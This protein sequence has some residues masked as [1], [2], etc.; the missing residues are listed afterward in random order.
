MRRSSVPPQSFE[1]G[2]PRAFQAAPRALD[3]RGW[4]S[5]GLAA[6]AVSAL[7]L[8]VAAS[9]TAT[10]SAEPAQRP[11]D[12][13][14]AQSRPGLPAEGSDAV[15]AGGSTVPGTAVPG[16]GTVTRAGSQPRPAV[17][18]QGALAAFAPQQAP[19]DPTE[20]QVRVAVVKERAAQRAEDLSR[21]AEDASRLTR[22]ASREAR[23]KNLA[24]TDREVRE[25]AVKIAT[26]R[27]QRAIAARVAAEFA[28]KQAEAAA[29]SAAAER[30][31]AAAAAAAAQQADT[32]STSRTPTG[33]VNLPTSSN[34]VSPVPGAVVGTPF[35]ATGLWARYHTGLDFRAAQGTPIRSV[36]AGVVL[37]AGNSGNWSG[38]H[39][40]IMH[41][42]GITTMSSHMSSMAVQAGDRVEAGQVIGRVGQ[43]GRAFGAHLHFEVYPRGVKYGDIYS[44]VN[45]LPWLRANG[46]RTR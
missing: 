5:H 25:T 40:A 29:A 3:R 18:A 46:V 33:D 11:A 4:L 22:T 14:V 34:G 30:E 6:L 43:T 2:S 7:G 27:R 26:A 37:Y 28:R 38:N 45:P 23:A 8:A 41:A 36:A 19:V 39:V 32:S 35:G 20:E 31:V 24:A 13:R 17:T 9:V 12:A 15:D 10:T 21:L 16:T 1:D 44:A 42:N